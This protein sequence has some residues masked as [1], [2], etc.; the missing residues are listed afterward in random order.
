MKPTPNGSNRTSF[1]FKG[2]FKP[3][4]LW[5]HGFQTTDKK[6]KKKRE[7]KRAFEPNPI[8]SNQTPLLRSST[9]AQLHYN[10]CR[11][12]ANTSLTDGT[13]SPAPGDPLTPSSD[14]AIDFAVEQ[15]RRQL[16]RLYHA[17]RALPKS[18]LGTQV[19]FALAKHHKK[20][21][22]SWDHL[23]PTSPAITTS[24]ARPFPW[25]NSGM[26]FP[27]ACVPPPMPAHQ[28]CP[29]FVGV[30]HHRAMARPQ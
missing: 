11:A 21:L 5:F 28:W 29:P 1:S 12:S 13:W 27:C 23:P 14:E 6:E 30:R 18:L 25:H 22:V 7:K 16:Q 8:G 3:D 15:A 26:F 9:P 17:A 24:R 10:S 19:A 20:S 4:T 2:V